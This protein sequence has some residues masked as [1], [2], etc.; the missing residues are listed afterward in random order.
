MSGEHEA[1]RSAVQMEGGPE[2]SHVSEE[3]G[4]QSSSYVAHESLKVICLFLLEGRV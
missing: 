3:V 2:G 4:D 1:A